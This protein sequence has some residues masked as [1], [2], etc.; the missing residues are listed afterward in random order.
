MEIFG[1]ST[2]N[3]DIILVYRIHTTARIRKLSPNNPSERISP[4]KSAGLFARS[5]AAPI[6]NANP[7]IRSESV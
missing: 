4:D 6:D 1:V 3:A 2:G 7:K 5:E